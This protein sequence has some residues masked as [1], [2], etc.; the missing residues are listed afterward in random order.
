VLNVTKKPFL[1]SSENLAR[2]NIE[3]ARAALCKWA[4]CTCQTFLFVNIC[5]LVQQTETTRTK[6]SGKSN[7]AYSLPIRVQTTIIH[8]SIRFFHHN[9]SV[10]EFF[11]QSASWKRHWAT[12][13]R[14]Q[15]GWKNGK[16]VNQITRLPAVV[17]KLNTPLFGYFYSHLSNYTKTIIRLRLVNI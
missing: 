10:K 4:T 8:I 12:H 15:R 14:E 16:L 9:I 3:G 1:N 5:K 11:F 17:V 13:W 2:S 7:D 6:C